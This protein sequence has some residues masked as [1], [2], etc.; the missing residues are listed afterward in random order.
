[1]LTYPDYE[2]HYTEKTDN[3]TRLLIT[4]IAVLILIIIIISISGL[5]NPTTVKTVSKVEEPTFIQRNSEIT[6]IR[7][8]YPYYRDYYSY[9]YCSQYI[10]EAYRVG[11]R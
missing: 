8:V 3:K 5:Q 10:A 1:M 9:D 6:S 7:Y 11:C 2:E 4:I